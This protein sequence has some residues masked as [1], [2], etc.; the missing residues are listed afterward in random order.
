MEAINSTE[1][2]TGSELAKILSVS[3]KTISNNSFKIVGRVKIGG[4]VR[5]NLETIRKEL[6]AGRNIFVR[7]DK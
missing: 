2:V 4:A 6:N 3:E 1:Y 7:G 5:Y